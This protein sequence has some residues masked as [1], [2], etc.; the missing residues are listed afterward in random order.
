MTDTEHPDPEDAP[1]T[2]QQTAAG[3]G[4]EE[5]EAGE[6]QEAERLGLEVAI[7]S[8][9]A[10]ERHVS[11]TVP[12][13]DIER[14]Y[15]KEYT[16]LM[17][18][19]QVPGFRPGHVPRRLLEKRFRKD[20]TEKVK[21]ALLMDSLAQI[22][23]EE[24]L[25]AISEPDIDLD[26]VEMPDDGPLTFEFD[27]EVRPEFELPQWK[28]L[29]L[30]K[31]VREF[32][33]ADVDR[34]LESV[35]ADRGRLVLY[36]GP[37]E[38]GDYVTVNVTFKHGD[39]VLST[40]EEQAIRIRPVL[41]FR[42]GSIE[43]F[44]ALMA[45][46]SAGETRV[47]ELELTEDAPNLALRGQKISGEFRV[48]EVKRLELPE[49]DAELLDELGG[50]ELEADLRDAVK[51]QLRRQLEYEQHRRAREQITAALT[52]AADWAL[53]PD[54]LERQS[55]RE[56]QRAV[57]E[58][59]RSGFSND[60]I[61]AHENE[62]R[63][64]SR[65]ATARA[66]KEHFMLERIAEEEQI[67]VS[68]EDYDREIALIAA[69]SRES[70][71]RVR[72]RLEKEG[73]MDVLR[74]QIVERKVIRL[75]LEHAEFKE[76]PYELERTDTVAIDRAAGGHQSDIPEAKPARLEPA[77]GGRPEEPPVRE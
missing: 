69:Q 41:S 57:M 51:D 10:C 64:N 32:S 29:R 44:D 46:V 22:S 9:S 26:A 38:A 25:S 61:L 72:A 73:A 24:E 54:L 20:V 48:L 27:L 14:Y 35:L 18:S 33:D 37:A 65:A 1:E 47:G 2:L 50:F 52:V 4:D 67:E 68:E 40:L 8:R 63:Q 11:V 55:H 34:A 15:D 62:L 45:G 23:E 39:E 76:V 42:D 58:L 5:L 28:G 6:Q 3:E 19:A 59:R 30:E 13:A 56:L 53:P 16:E 71:R 21:T 12:R 7:E 66:L 77:P 75:I 31:P 17:P 36:D 49:L 60:E 70:P 74:N 43:G